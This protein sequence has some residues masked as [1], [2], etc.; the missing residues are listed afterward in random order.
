MQGGDGP[1]SL[2]FKGVHAQTDHRAIHRINAPVRTRGR[3][4]TEV[5]LVQNVAK[6]ATRRCLSFSE[7]SDYHGHQRAGT[8]I[9]GSV[10]DAAPTVLEWEIGS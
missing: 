9:D 7:Y 4:L 5:T 1:A 10:S 2:L 3:A 6:A 8:R